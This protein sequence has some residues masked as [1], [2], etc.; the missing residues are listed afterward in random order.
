MDMLLQAPSKIQ[1]VEHHPALHFDEVGSFMQTLRQR[2]G[3]GAKALEYAI[4]TAA[5]SGEVRGLKW[6]ELN[7][8]EESATLP[9][10]R[11]KGKREHKVALSK[12]AL[13]ILNSLPRTSD[14]VFPNRDGEMLSDMALTEVIRAMDE[15]KA[16]ETGKGWRDLKGEVVTAHG[17]RSTFR[18][19]CSERT[20]HPS[21][22]AEMALA[23]S[24]RNKVEAAYRR[25]DLFE[26]RRNLM[27]D[28]DKYCSR[29][30]VAPNVIPIGIAASK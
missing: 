4:L 30:F 22:V 25:G 10:D 27:R 18:D 28:W 11:M 12:G 19:W 7:S 6:A 8:T 24:V 21:E 3:M 5:R 2:E 20:N 14:L 23:H 16:Q 1:I 13:A 17:F 15:K 26:K 9:A 29:V